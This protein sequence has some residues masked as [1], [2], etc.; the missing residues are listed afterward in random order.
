MKNFIKENLVLVIGLTLPLLLIVLFFVA[1]VIPKVMGTPPQYEML[2]TTN[3]YD[4]QNPADYLLE[5][6]VKNQ[7]LTIKVRKNESKDKN[8]TSKKLMAYDGKTET[9]REIVVDIAKTTEA[10][11]GNAVVLE[12]TKNMAIDTS[13]ISP[14][15]YSLDGPS[16]GGSGLVGG[17]FGGGYRNSGF[18]LKKGGVGYQVPNTQQNTY[19]NQMQF[20]G[21]VIKK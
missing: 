8:Y 5:F 4:Y 3:H 15:G 1:T 12:E 18:R 20:I 11:T 19:Y 13:S 17:F 21:W 9:V 2:F 14:D 16:Y 7:Q 6:A 10:T